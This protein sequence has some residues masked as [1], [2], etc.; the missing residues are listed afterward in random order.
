MMNKRNWWPNY[1]AP[2]ILG[3]VLA[4]LLFAMHRESWWVLLVVVVL[5]MIGGVLESV[6]FAARTRATS[7][8][9]VSGDGT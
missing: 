1:W 9:N 3:I 5:W 8:D 6:H 4:A 2:V 7:R